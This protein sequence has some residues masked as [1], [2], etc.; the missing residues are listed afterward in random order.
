MRS[1][2]AL[3]RFGRLTL[4]L[5]TFSHQALTHRAR[6]VRAWIQMDDWWEGRIDTAIKAWF[7]ASC[8]LCKKCKDLRKVHA[9]NARSKNTTLIW[10]KPYHV[11]NVPYVDVRQRTAYGNTWRRCNQA[12]WFLQQHS[13][14][15]PPSSYDDLR[16][17]TSPYIDARG[18]D[19]VKLFVPNI[20]HIHYIMNHTVNVSFI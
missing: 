6:Q 10:H 4:G 16:C 14:T 13:H 1:Y 17:R 8:T 12:Y 9:S 15:H 7:P 3:Y 19:N 20:I 11:T 18:H 2:S 5:H